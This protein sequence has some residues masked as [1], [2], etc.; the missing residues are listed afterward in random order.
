MGLETATGRKGAMFARKDPWRWRSGE[1]VVAPRCPSPSTT[2]PRCRPPVPGSFL[3]P[4]PV[5]ALWCG[6][7]SNWMERCLE[8]LPDCCVHD[9]NPY[10]YLRR[11]RYRSNGR[12]ACIRTQAARRCVFVRVPDIH[13]TTDA[14]AETARRCDLS[15]MSID[16]RVI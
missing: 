6:C 8:P 5:L 11:A 3:A 2:H 15:P 1:V 9:H 10:L 7:P 4:F 16:E 14:G 13:D 12:C